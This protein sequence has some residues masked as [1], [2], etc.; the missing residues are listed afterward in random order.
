MHWINRM[1]VTRKQ[2]C[3]NWRE[4]SPAVVSLCS[5]HNELMTSVASIK[6]LS[7]IIRA[8][9]IFFW[10]KLRASLQQGQSLNC[11]RIVI[12]RQRDQKERSG[13]E[14]RPKANKP[15]NNKQRPQPVPDQS[16]WEGER[17][18]G[19]HGN[20]QFPALT[21]SSAGNSQG[22][23][24]CRQLRYSSTIIDL[25]PLLSPALGYIF[26]TTNKLQRYDLLFL[27]NLSIHASKHS[28]LTRKLYGWSWLTKLP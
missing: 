10:T 16:G 7:V 27:S 5:L 12:V 19:S 11:A 21:T 23:M 18:S 24:Q 9:L 8:L 22:P 25:L 20:L 4:Y 13:T 26:L 14:K 3:T 15:P 28:L 2:K 1:C 6:H 17:S